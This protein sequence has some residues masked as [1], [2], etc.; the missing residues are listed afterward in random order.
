MSEQDT[1]PTA[2]ELREMNQQL[3]EQQK[4]IAAFLDLIRV[5]QHTI[6]ERRTRLNTEHQQKRNEL[7]QILIDLQKRCPHIRTEYHPDASG[8]NDWWYECLDCGK[9]GKNI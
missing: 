8:N 5:E 7:D 3:L 6:N 2:Q 4:K 9:D 1:I